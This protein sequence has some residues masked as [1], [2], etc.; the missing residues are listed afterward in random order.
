DLR[1]VMVWPQTHLPLLVQSLLVIR[2]TPMHQS[3]LIQMLGIV[4]LKLR[5]L[6]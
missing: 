3:M 2:L 1:P 4:G 6:C 5:I